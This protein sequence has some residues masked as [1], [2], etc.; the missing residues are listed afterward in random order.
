MDTDSDSDRSPAGDRWCQGRRRG[1]LPV[2]RLPEALCPYTRSQASVQPVSNQHPLS[3]SLKTAYQ[4]RITT[5]SQ[6]QAYSFTFI[7]AAAHTCSYPL[8]LPLSHAQN[9]CYAA[10]QPGLQPVLHDDSC[11]AT[12]LR[13]H[14]LVPQPPRTL[15]SSLG[16]AC[17]DYLH[18]T[19]AVETK[20]TCSAL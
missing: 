18:G 11:D 4:Q 19:A 14:S 5:E 13:A 9:D 10:T 8:T 6:P 12:G 20:N 15:G 16:T 1:M 2:R 3:D 7:H 17:G